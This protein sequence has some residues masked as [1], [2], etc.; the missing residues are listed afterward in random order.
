[1]KNKIKTKQLK[2]LRIKE[3]HAK[4]MIWVM[5]RDKLIEKI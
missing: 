4:I 2:E 5:N 3:K 1:L